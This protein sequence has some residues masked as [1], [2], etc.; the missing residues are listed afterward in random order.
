M[1]NQSS[2]V[3]RATTP[4][5]TDARITSPISESPETG[6]RYT[7]LRPV[8]CTR[9]Y[10]RGIPPPPFQPPPELRTPASRSISVSIPPLR[11]TCRRNTRTCFHSP[12]CVSDRLLHV[13]IIRAASI[14][15]VRRSTNF[16]KA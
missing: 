12:W 10:A 14:K 7:S 4:Y 2:F 5:A 8:I 15:Y 13:L 1:I 6:L 16:E 3:N 9:D 11:R